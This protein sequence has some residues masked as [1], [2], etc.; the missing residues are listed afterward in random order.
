MGIS[1]V[2]NANGER[3]L[4]IVVSEIQAKIN[5]TNYASL[6]LVC[7][8]LVAIATDSVDNKNLP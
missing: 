1:N 6:F 4:D 8:K 7:E 5:F 2:Q 3:P